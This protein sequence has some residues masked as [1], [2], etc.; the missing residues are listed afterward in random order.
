MNGTDF[1][2][3]ILAGNP[4]TAPL[5][6]ASKVREG[7][8]GKTPKTSTTAAEPKAPAPK[9]EGAST[10]PDLP[11]QQPIPPGG[12][13]GAGL[14]QILETL[15]RLQTQ[16]AAANR[17][18]QR[19]EAQRAR[20]AQERQVELAREYYP[21]Q[22]QIDVETYRKQAD[23][24]QQIGM[25]KMREN[26]AR[27]IELQTINAWQ[28]ITQAQINRDTAMGLGMMNLAYAAGVPNPNV[29]QA[30]ASLVGQGR[31]G[32]GTPSSTIS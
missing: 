23:I 6:V 13:S 12:A 30:G 8:S 32:F 5:V 2:E 25:E 9:P 31:A 24:A 3:T 10:T 16:E 4:I 28:N 14:P 20:E 29:L 27:Q 17:Q 19:E 15:I 11:T 7:L 18:A 22:A 1:L 26:T 21:V